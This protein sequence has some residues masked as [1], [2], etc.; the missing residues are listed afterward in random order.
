MVEIGED[1]EMKELEKRLRNKILSVE[2]A[3]LK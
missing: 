1:P 2:R 3:K